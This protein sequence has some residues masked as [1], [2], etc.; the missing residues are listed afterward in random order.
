[1]GRQSVHKPNWSPPKCP[2][3]N[4]HIQIELRLCPPN[5][6]LLSLLFSSH[7]CLFIQTLVSPIAQVLSKEVILA[8]SLS[9]TTFSI[10]SMIK[11]SNFHFQSISWLCP[12][13]CI[14]I[15][16]ILVWATRLVL[17]VFIQPHS[18]WPC[19]M[20]CLSHS[21]SPVETKV[22]V[23]VYIYFSCLNPPSLS[24]AFIKPKVLNM[25]TTLC[26]I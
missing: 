5:L 20:L 4:E 17:P 2:M 12:L 7:Q 16:S 15:A 18:C 22:T 26:L 3:N 1:M 23:L 8:F 25:T 9:I 13:F 6:P 24:D 11:S 10:Q 19:P 14:F 21:F